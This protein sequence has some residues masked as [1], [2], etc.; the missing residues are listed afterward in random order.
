MIHTYDTST[1]LCSL[2]T[3]TSL[4]IEIPDQ[5]SLK[6]PSRHSMH[7][8]EPGTA[9]GAACRIAR[10]RIGSTLDGCRN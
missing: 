6:P 2:A 8:C 3:R 1:K 4:L 7:Y 10:P 5:S 9:I